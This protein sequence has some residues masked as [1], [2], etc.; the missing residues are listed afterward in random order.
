[1]GT[2]CCRSCA[3]APARVTVAGIDQNAIEVRIRI[4]KELDR[5]VHDEVVRFVGEDVRD[6]LEEE[7]ISAI[8]RD[9]YRAKHA[10]M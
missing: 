5:A 1:M 4:L 6:D 9:I 7:A 10:Q 2:R 8:K 3:C